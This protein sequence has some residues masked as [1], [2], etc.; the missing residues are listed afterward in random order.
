MKHRVGIL[1]VAVVLGLLGWLGLGSLRAKETLPGDLDKSGAIDAA[2][3]VL[4]ANYQAGNLDPLPAQCGYLFEVDSIV[5]V[6]RGVPAGTFTQG[7]PGDEPCR[8]PDETQFSHTLTRDLAV[9]ATEVTRRMWADL[10]AV[11]PTLPVDPTNTS[12]GAGVNNPVQNNTWYEA[13]LF[14]NLLSVERGL[15]RCYYTDAGFTTPIDAANYTTGPF[16]CNWDANGYRLP[17][18]GEWEYC[19]R[20]GTATPFW[21]AEPDFTSGDCS[22]YPTTPG[23][24]PQLESAAWL[25][26]NTYDPAGDFTSKP[27]GLKTPNPWGLYDTHGNVWERCWDWYGGYPSGSATDHLGASPDLFRVIR[28]GYWSDTAGY[29]R[30]ACRGNTSPDSRNI[31]IGF[32]LVR[33]IG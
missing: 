11:Q 30:S 15:V 2:D 26:A 32:R 13:V 5:G 28:G 23:T 12:W 29:C 31:G 14:A 6:L 20:A 16:Y 22:S 10:L 8:I 18:E 17:S 33:T 24:W 3:L 27:V 19:C 25:C 7:S 1:G 9:M 4:L 21:I